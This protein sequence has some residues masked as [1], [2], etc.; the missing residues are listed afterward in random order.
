MELVDQVLLFAATSTAR[1]THSLRELQVDHVIADAVQSTKGLLEKA[2][3]TIEVQVEPAL[4]PVTCDLSLLSQ[5]LQNLIAN[6]VKYSPDNRWVGISARMNEEGREV[7]IN[8]QDCGIGI[9]ASDL[10]HIFE[11][12]YRS[13][14]VV[15]AH[16]PGTGLGLSISK[17]SVEALGGEL[18]VS[19]QLGVGSVFTVRLP[20]ANESLHRIRMAPAARTGT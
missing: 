12:F 16:I 6:A 17:R 7:D 20:F 18:N 1:P 3:F 10:A 2:G 5:C 14:H 4:P 8:V 13:P 9:P 15:A 11:P 19:S